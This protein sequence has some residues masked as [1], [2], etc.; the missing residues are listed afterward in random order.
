MT[1]YPWH[2]HTWK[3]QNLAYSAEHCHKKA[4]VKFK[5][6]WFEI[7]REKVKKWKKS[8]RLC[9]INKSDKMGHSLPI[10][11]SCIKLTKHQTDQTAWIVAYIMHKLKIMVKYEQ[12]FCDI[13]GC[14]NISIHYLELQ[15]VIFTF[16]IHLLVWYL[17]DY[18]RSRTFFWGWLVPLLYSLVVGAENEGYIDEGYKGN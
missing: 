15:W 10:P 2:I 16:L 18:G 5:P 6:D 7:F 4:N 11:S 1:N 3:R 14:Y 8:H 13:Y 17:T 9:I 12:W